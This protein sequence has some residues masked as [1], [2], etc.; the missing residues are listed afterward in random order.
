M[1]GRGKGAGV[2][3]VRRWEG[4]K[5]VGKEQRRWGRRKGG[6]EGGKGRRWEGGK[7]MGRRWEGKT[8]VGRIG[9]EKGGE[10]E[11]MRGRGKV[12]LN[13]IYLCCML[14]WGGGSIAMFTRSA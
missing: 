9:T 12:Q 3:R 10:G 4:R 11:G 1:P 7:E 2:E 8:E 13:L 14:D 6:G 5:E